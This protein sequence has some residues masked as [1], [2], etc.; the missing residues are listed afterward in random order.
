MSFSGKP[1]SKSVRRDGEG[2]HAVRV[3]SAGEEVSGET[4]LNWQ[5]GSDGSAATAAST[6][7]QKSNVRDAGLEA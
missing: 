6:Q 1:G 7:A 4:A 5:V 3:R 2:W